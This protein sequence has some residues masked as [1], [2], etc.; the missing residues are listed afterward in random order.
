MI[1][2]QPCPSPWN[3]RLQVI[4]LDTYK[5]SPLGKLSSMDGY[6]HRFSLITKD[7]KDK[8]THNDTLLWSED[9]M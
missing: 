9:I 3:M 2:V 7:I 6:I 1:Q 5:V 4:S 8:V